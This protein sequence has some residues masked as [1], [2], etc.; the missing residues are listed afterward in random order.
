MDN[1]PRP[2][3]MKEWIQRQNNAQ[4]EVPNGGAMG[5]TTVVGTVQTYSSGLPTVLLDDAV[6]VLPILSFPGNYIPKTG[7]VVA[8]TRSKRGWHIIEHLVTAL[9]SDP[10][11]TY[12]PVWSSDGTAP[13]IGNG[14][15]HG[16]YKLLTPNS[17]AVRINMIVG[18][19]TGGGNGTLYWSLPTGFKSATT[20]EQYGVAKLYPPGAG[21]LNFNGL[22]YL[23]G[24]ASKL[25]GLF[26]VSISD[27]RTF[28]MRNA[29]GTNSSGTGY[30]AIS[31]HYPLESGGN[32][33]TQGVFE[34]AAA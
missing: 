27:S 3:S 18:S 8:C 16:S 15:L 14:T 4:R 32:F 9:F 22:A 29:D 19:T 10:W 13:T 30:P 25:A 34:I 6:T 12:T 28:Y 33:A 23:A 31:G 2:D 1:R 24:G 21:G 20:D 11:T 5:P 7:D 17:L 26:P